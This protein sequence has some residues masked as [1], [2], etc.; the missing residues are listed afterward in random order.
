MICLPPQSSNTTRR[1]VKCVAIVAGESVSAERCRRKAKKNWCC[2]WHCAVTQ[3]Q[4]LS[5]E[6]PYNS[7]QSSCCTGGARLEIPEW[8]RWKK[9]MCFEQVGKRVRILRVLVTPF[10]CACAIMCAVM[11]LRGPRAL[12][13]FSFNFVILCNATAWAN[14]KGNLFAKWKSCEAIFFTQIIRYAS[15]ITRAFNALSSTAHRVW[16]EKKS[17]HAKELQ[18]FQRVNVAWPTG[19]CGWKHQ[20]RVFLCCFFFCFVLT[21]LSNEWLNK[22]LKHLFITNSLRIFCFQFV[23]AATANRH[24]DIVRSPF[25]TC[26]TTSEYNFVVVYVSDSTHTLTHTRIR[27]MCADPLTIRSMANDSSPYYDRSLHFSFDFIFL[28]LL[29]SQPNQNST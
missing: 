21:S 28:S 9:K 17:S 29:A 16:A 27:C 13:T 25:S 26:R 11:C 18:I 1:M 2:R 5:D 6:R 10:P 4:V 3:V 19:M 7:E 22:L 14:M 20:I 15:R 23:I 12:S 8:G 24:S